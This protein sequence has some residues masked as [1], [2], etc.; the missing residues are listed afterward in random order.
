MTLGLYILILFNHYNYV[1]SLMAAPAILPHSPC[2]YEL[3]PYE[4]LTLNLERWPS[5]RHSTVNRTTESP[6][7]STFSVLDYIYLPSRNI[8]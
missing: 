5:Y 7:L 8:E 6:P 4:I 2:F 3:N 1:S